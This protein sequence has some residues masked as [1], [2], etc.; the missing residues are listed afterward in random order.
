MRV[1]I[2]WQK[3]DATNVQRLRKHYTS[4]RNAITQYVLIIDMIVR[5]ATDNTVVITSK[6]HAPTVKRKLVANACI[7]WIKRY[8]LTVNKK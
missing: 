7:T 3:L 6:K 4:A 2:S 5:D 1:V 8:A